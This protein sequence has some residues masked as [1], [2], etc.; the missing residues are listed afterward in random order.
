MD[1]LDRLPTSQ[2][3]NVLLDSYQ[4]SPYAM[5]AAS[6]VYEINKIVSICT[7][8]HM[9]FFIFIHAH[10]HMHALIYEHVCTMFWAIHLKIHEMPNL[11][12]FIRSR[13]VLS[14]GHA[15]SNG[16]VLECSLVK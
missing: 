6:K 4:T 13:I 16:K 7:C 5:Q 1:P 8:I 11:H 9:Q 12:V 10:I 3:I 14:S 2:V 15:Q